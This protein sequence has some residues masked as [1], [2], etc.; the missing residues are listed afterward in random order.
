[1]RSWTGTIAKHIQT[2]FSDT[3]T[4]LLLGEHHR[5]GTPD[6]RQF[7][8]LWTIHSQENVF[9][10]L[11]QPSKHFFMHGDSR[12]IN[13]LVYACYYW[14]ILC[15]SLSGYRREE[16][17]VSVAIA[18]TRLG[19]VPLWHI[20]LIYDPFDPKNHNPLLFLFF[21]LFSLWSTSSSS[22]SPSSS[23]STLSSIRSSRSLAPVKRY[24]KM[25]VTIH[26]KL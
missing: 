12:S 23:S 19:F 6:M 20:F 14:D 24:Q 5:T 18:S 4:C 15:A 7:R 13:C 10:L 17:L 22:E 11:W 2:I 16:H 9:R 8:L 25:V 21:L 26:G 1:M 3:T